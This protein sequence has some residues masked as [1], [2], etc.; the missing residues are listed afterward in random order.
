MGPPVLKLPEPAL[1][2]DQGE[3]DI[4]GPEVITRPNT[5]RS[6][7]DTS[8]V[9]ERSNNLQFRTAARPQRSLTSP[10][11]PVR[12]PT[13]FKR[14]MS[15]YSY[16][17]PSAG[18]L[19]VPLEAYHEFDA[20]QAEFFHFLDEELE[21]VEEFYK[22]KEEEANQRIETLKEQLQMMKIK[23]AEETRR[24]RAAN[25][26][27]STTNGHTGSS[28]GADASS[29]WLR[30]ITRGSK[31]NQE[32]LFS[33]APQGNNVNT[34]HNNGG[35]ALDGQRDVNEVKY[36][37]AKSILKH[38]LQEFYKILEMLK[39]YAMVN[40]TA[41]RKINKKYDKAIGTRR[42]KYMSEKVDRAWFVQSSVLESH[43]EDVENLYAQYFEKGS[44]K[45]A[46]KKLRAKHQTDYSSN[47]FRTGL[48]LGAGTVLGVRAMMYASQI[49][50]ASSPIVTVQTKYLLQVIASAIVMRNQPLIEFRYMAA[51]FSL[52]CSYFCFVLTAS[53]G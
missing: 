26:F 7:A 11:T 35:D 39:S 16:R 34:S 21:K 51:T 19:G 25:P 30:R 12:R 42:G 6:D 50:T 3:Y 9:H 5:E 4:R 23:Q 45:A 36:S 27:R 32:Q 8:P 43:L 33:D 2:S 46:V 49:Y 14:I 31:S 15:T 44:H 47:S 52:C 18:V 22:E 28:T 13:L 38:A 1:G 20:C 24:D 41:F 48:L 29:K 40:R 53:Y 37:Q 17:G 10:F